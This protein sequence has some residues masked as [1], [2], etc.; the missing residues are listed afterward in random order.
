[1]NLD[2]TESTADYITET[3]F[4]SAER[5]NALIEA[6]D[7][8]HERIAKI[9]FDRLMSAPSVQDLQI[10]VEY[11]GLVEAIVFHAGYTNFGHDIGTLMMPI[12][13]MFKASFHKMAD[14]KATEIMDTQE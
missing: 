7:E 3:I 14:A 9:E 11:W 1:M 5:A 6:Y 4:A 13:E 10:A 12:G 2:K 8:E